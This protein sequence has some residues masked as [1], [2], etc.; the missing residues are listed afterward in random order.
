ML[1]KGH[2]SA[3]LE[4]SVFTETSAVATRC[5]CC[6]MTQES[7]PATHTSTPGSSKGSTGS[8]LGSP[9]WVRELPLRVSEQIWRWRAEWESYL[10][11]MCTC[12]VLAGVNRG[13]GAAAAGLGRLSH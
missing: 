1:L 4:P 3:D 8:V 11:A 9:S 2:L 7:S 13:C 10:E 12:T 5:D 6:H